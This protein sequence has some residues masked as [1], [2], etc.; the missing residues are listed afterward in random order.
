MF[1]FCSFVECLLLSKLVFRKGWKA[2]A[3]LS[4]S[5]PLSPAIY[6]CAYLVIYMSIHVCT[7]LYMHIHQNYEYNMYVC[8]YI[9]NQSKYFE[10]ETSSGMSELRERIYIYIYIYIDILVGHRVAPVEHSI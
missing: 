5:L 7:H 9:Y 3:S 1:R 8:I 4:L 6:L 10:P 2:R